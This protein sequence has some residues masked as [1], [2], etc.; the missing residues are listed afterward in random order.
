MNLTDE[1]NGG[2]A[3]YTPFTLKIYD[4]AV[5]GFSNQFLWRCPTVH[6]RNLYN[7]NVSAN[8]LDVGVGTGYF[9]DKAK[10]P[11][12]A[13]R[14]TLLDLNSHSLKAAEDRISRFSP[15]SVIANV[16]D[17]LPLQEKFESIALNYLLHCLPG[18][19]SKKAPRVFGNISGHLADK[20]KVFGSTIL[21]G[22]VPRSR[23][24][25]ALM[26]F[27]NSKGIFA[28]GED[29]VEDLHEALEQSFSGHSITQHGAVA[30]FEAW[31]D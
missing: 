28:N 31:K 10:W 12:N 16:L 24:A 2:Q 1:I 22:D 15:K 8:H 11:S 4:L 25:Q 21:Q 30:I 20:G 29:T 27:Y 19:L 3:V 14:I 5:L 18:K 17:P 26:N 23:P 9:L 6:L 7:R 13:P